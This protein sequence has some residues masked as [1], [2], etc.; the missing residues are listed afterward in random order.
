M[1]KLIKKGAKLSEENKPLLW[2]ELCLFAVV[3]GIFFHSWLVFTVN[4][5]EPNGRMRFLEQ[6]EIIKVLTKSNK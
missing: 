1:F 2:S 4:R 6:K 5:K 3:G